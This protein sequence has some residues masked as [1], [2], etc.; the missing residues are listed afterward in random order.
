M[1]YSKHIGVVLVVG[2]FFFFSCTKNFTSINTDPGRPSTVTPGVILPQLEYRMVSSSINVAR[3]FTHELMQVS[4]PRI[5][6]DGLGVHRYYINASNGSGF[7]NSMYGYMTDIYDIYNI[8][9][10]L[11]E[12]NYKAIALVYKSWAYS[13]LTDVFGNIPYS[14]AID[15][16]NKNFTPAFDNQKDIYTQI[17]KDLS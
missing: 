11:N 8:S 12:P 2:S 6:S 13:M 4:A 17:L 3:S 16:A 14:K 7:W 5:S 1:K 15:A 9:D 10:K